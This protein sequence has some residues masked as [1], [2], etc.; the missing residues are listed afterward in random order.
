MKA[1]HVGILI[2]LIA[3]VITVVPFLILILNACFDWHGSILENL[4]AELE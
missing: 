3:S 2:V 1:K 4:I